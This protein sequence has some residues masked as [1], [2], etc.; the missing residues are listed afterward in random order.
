MIL[1]GTGDVKSS[2]ILVGCYLDVTLDIVKI[3]QQTYG[4]GG[5]WI[6][7]WAMTLRFLS[8]EIFTI[9][10]MLSPRKWCFAEEFPE[11]FFPNWWTA[12]AYPDAPLMQQWGHLLGMRM[13]NNTM[14]GTEQKHALVKD[15][16]IFQLHNHVETKN[17]ESTFDIVSWFPH[18]KWQWISALWSSNTFATGE[19]STA[20]QR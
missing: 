8:G 2:G 4:Q 6:T 14:D 15:S 7:D 9:S 13:S 5:G 16:V 10:R 1:S 19:S 18:Q 20:S 11:F 17:R 3:H 12:K